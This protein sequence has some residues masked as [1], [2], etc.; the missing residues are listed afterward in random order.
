[1]WCSIHAVA[2]NSISLLVTALCYEALLPVAHVRPCWIT[3]RQ[4]QQISGFWPARKPC[5]TEALSPSHSF[6]SGV[7][8]LLVVVVVDGNNFHLSCCCEDSPWLWLLLRETS[9]SKLGGNTGAGS[10]IKIDPV[11]G[12]ECDG[13]FCLQALACTRVYL[14][15]LDWYREKSII[16]S[17]KIVVG[18]TKVQ[19]LLWNTSGLVFVLSVT[20]ILENKV[21]FVV[22]MLKICFCLFWFYLLRVEPIFCSFILN[23]LYFHVL[24]LDIQTFKS[25][26]CENSPRD[27]ECKGPCKLARDCAGFVS[28]MVSSF[29][30][31][32]GVLCYWLF[33][34]QSV[35]EIS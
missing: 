28:W 11:G 35:A 31:N 29:C 17:E 5:E 23:I 19:F 7:L 27:S 6:A 12:T 32:I 21:F 8:V 4:Q 30:V 34:L 15:S 33:N 9:H 13:A 18:K 14:E 24:N 20:L 25:L 3:V 22:S 2:T 26:F 16:E 1:M 10:V